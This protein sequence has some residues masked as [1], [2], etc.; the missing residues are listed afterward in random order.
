[1]SCLRTIISGEKMG[2]EGNASS[3]CICENIIMKPVIL[4]N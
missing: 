1:M 3:L 4:Y 2:Y